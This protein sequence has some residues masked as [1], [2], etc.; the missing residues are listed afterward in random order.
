MKDLGLHY[1][2]GTY[3]DWL[4]HKDEMK[5]RKM[6]ALDAVSRKEAH[7]Q[8]SI[9]QAHS[10][11]DD[12]QA[13]SKAKKLDRASF[14]RS[15]DGHKFKLF[16]LSKLDEAAVHMPESVE[17]EREKDFR[18]Y[19]FKFPVVDP[20]QLRLP[21]PN[22]PLLTLEKC[23]LAFQGK[24]KPLLNDITLQLTLQSRVGIIGRNGK[25]KTTLLNALAFAETVGPIR[26]P[27]PAKITSEARDQDDAKK[28]SIIHP[29][30]S[31]T[32]GKIWRHHNLRIGMVSQHQIDILSEH[33][34]E[35]P[36]TYVTKI[37]ALSSE[38]STTIKESEVRAHLGAFGISGNLALQKIGSLSGGQKARLS[39]A[40]VCACKPHLLFLDE[41]SNHLSLDAI[42][43]LISAC[44][45]FTGGIVLVS[46]NRQLIGSVCKELYCIQGESMVIRRVD[47]EITNEEEF[48]D[49]FNRLLEN[50]IKEQLRTP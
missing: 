14:V 31:L 28:V 33:L 46:H 34:W 20:I 36:L 13:K 48:R 15:L 30:I 23:T 21:T 27:S 8:K 44:K 42:E 45:E 4:I 26:F 3:D 7:I 47:G 10:R 5:S 49:D 35:T 37:F 43:G 6:N 50:C 38:S 39:F 16:S 24:P 2:P 12:K 19:K 22:S 29:K 17:G 32:K 40:V 25:G 1:F 9:D 11:G 18:L 41:P